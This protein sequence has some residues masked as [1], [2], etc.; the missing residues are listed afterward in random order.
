MPF[1]K[2]VGHID[3]SLSQE[4][5]MKEYRRRYALAAYHR[6]RTALIAKL[7]GTC[8]LCGSTESLNFARKPDAPKTIH[9]NRLASMSEKNRKK[10]LPHVRLLCEEHL[11][12]ELY[13]K[14]QITHG[15]WYSAYK[16]K[17]RCDDCYEFMADYNLRRQEDRRYAKYATPGGGGE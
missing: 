2:T 15:T 6:R 16:K 13:D 11:R 7:G 14:D 5:V 8:E 3:D 17:C 12:T 1:F 9:V 10:C 4:E